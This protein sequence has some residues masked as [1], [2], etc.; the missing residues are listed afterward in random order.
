MPKVTAASFYPSRRLP[1][2]LGLS[3]SVLALAAAPWAV[4][5]STPTAA[6]NYHKKVAPILEKYCYDCH[7]NGLEK[8]KVSF[9]TFASDK[10]ML[11]KRDLWLAALKN[12]RAGMMPPREEGAEDFRPNAEELATLTN[13]IKFEAFG[14][15]VKNPDPGRVTVRRL[16]RI[17]YRNTI[18]DLMG[19]DFNSEVEFPPDDTGGGFDNNGDVLTISPLLMEKYLAAAEKIVETAVPKVY[20]ELRERTVS[21]REI[22]GSDGANGDRLSVRKPARIS[23]SFSAEVAD[24]YRVTVEFEVRGSF[25]FDAG[26][27]RFVGK[28]DG[29]EKFTENIA[30]SERR[31]VRHEYELAWKAGNH[32]VSFEVEPE[33]VETESSGTG[34]TGGQASTFVTVRVAS[35]QVV[36]PLSP[37]H[38]QVAKNHPR[39]FP[40]GAAPADPA[41]RDAYAQKVLRTFASKAFRR[42]VD[43]PHLKQLVEVARKVY[44]LPG[45]TFEEGIQRAMMAVLSSPRFLFRVE[46]PEAKYASQPIAPVDEYSLASRLSYFLWSTMPDAELMALADK[47]EL[48]KNLKPQVTRMLKDAKAQA[49]VKHF[50]GQWLQARDVESVPINARV[51]LGPNAPRNRDGRIEFDGQFRRWMRSETEM[52]FDYVIKED[53]SLLELIDSDYTFLNERLAQ[54]YGIP[55]VKGENLRYTKLPEGSVRGGVL[56]QGTVLAV[57]SNPT[58]TSPV[59]RGLF[60]LENILGTPPPPAPPNVPDLEE[61]KDRFKGREP[62]LAE[63]LAVHR[64]NKLCSSC[65]E[66]MDPL[67]LAME[68][69]NALGSWRDKDAG[70]PIEAGGKLVTGE[71]FADVRELKKII[72]KNH[73]SDVYHCLTEKLMTYALGRGVEYYDTQA[74]DE[75]VAALEKDGGKMSTLLMGVIESAP[76]QKQRTQST[77]ASAVSL[78][79]PAR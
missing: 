35:V 17:E 44:S 15:D 10:D 61:S 27:A 23:R 1:L 62:K 78:V 12:V 41:K 30:W 42:P 38:W 70:Q 69:F 54:H 6:A 46:E 13:W 31:T 24:K 18:S 21:G 25:D 63:M 40:D 28:I 68:N 58:R 65:H 77:K 51:V 3:L 4:A 29:E 9:D 56:T 32:T 19:I 22:R 75:I 36:G 48:R 67:G 79:A 43:E 73:A 45:K 37:E 49:F 11:A 26:K 76:F 71:P 59:K 33:P 57:T 7:G 39:F 34:G 5:E 2:P 55:D 8:G 52:Y 50:T 64:E 74:I 47:G 66:R 53:R 60:I 20:R 16:N 14:T 72:V